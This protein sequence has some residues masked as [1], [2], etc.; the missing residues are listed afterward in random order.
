[1]SN[2]FDALFDEI[3]KSGDRNDYASKPAPGEH[4]VMLQSA[5]VLPTR[6]FGSKFEIEFTI[7]QST[8]DQVGARRGEGFFVGA[9]GDSGTIAKQRARALGKAVLESLGIPVN[10]RAISETLAK[11]KD[12]GQ[13]LKGLTL[14]CIATESESKKDGKIHTNLV[15]E[16]IPQT[17]EQVKAARVKAESQL[18]AAPASTPAAPTVPS[19]IRD[20]AGKLPF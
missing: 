18:V 9:P 5:K 13:P 3:G 7:L 20:D 2:D 8:S 10:D 17:M 12:Q 11:M 1:M 15:Y 19:L 14:R 6:N 16:A 4:V